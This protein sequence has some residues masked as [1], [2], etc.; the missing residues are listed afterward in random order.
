MN[1]IIMFGMARLTLPMPQTYL[2]GQHYEVKEEALASS[3]LNISGVCTVSCSIS[4]SL[5]TGQTNF[6]FCGFTPVEAPADMICHTYLN[7][8]QALP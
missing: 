3:I 1:T 5:F 4:D 6:I 2:A 8:R 7:I